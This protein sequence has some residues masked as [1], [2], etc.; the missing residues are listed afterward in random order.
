M[1]SVPLKIKKLHEDAVIPSYANPGDAGLDLTAISLE[2]KEDIDC[3][4]YGTGLAIEIPQG[5]VGLLFPRSSNRRTDAYMCNHVGVV[6]SGYRGEVMASFKLRDKLEE[7][8]M[9]R[10]FAPYEIGERVCQ[11]VIVPVPGA[12]IEVVDELSDSARG[13]NGHGSSGK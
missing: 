9:P 2:Y 12:D 8:N 4:V 11:L 5:H 6:D 1:Y 3:Y 7:G 13:A 10:L